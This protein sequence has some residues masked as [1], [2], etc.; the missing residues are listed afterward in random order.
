M[1]CIAYLSVNNAW[2]GD[3]LSTF[4]L[5]IVSLEC[6]CHILESVSYYKGAHEKSLCFILQVLHVVYFIRFQIL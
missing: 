1:M 4:V 6:I 3:K 5:F 2:I